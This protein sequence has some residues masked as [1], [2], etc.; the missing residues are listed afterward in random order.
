MD[1]YKVLYSDLNFKVEEGTYFTKD[2]LNDADS[3]YAVAG[4]LADEITNTSNI[5]ISGHRY[6]VKGTFNDNKKPSN[7]PILNPLSDGLLWIRGMDV[8]P[9][10]TTEEK[11]NGELIIA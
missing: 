11:I 7:I 10:L 5:L 6:T 8:L 2:E 3:Y 9:L 1:I 4:S